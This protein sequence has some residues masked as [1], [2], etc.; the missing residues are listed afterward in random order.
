MRSKSLLVSAIALLLLTSATRPGPAAPLRSPAPGL[1][2]A[3]FAGGCFWSM[4]SAFE[5]KPGVRSVISGYTG[6]TKADPTYDQVSTGTTGHLEAIQVTYDPKVT[7]YAALLDI[8]WH[9]IDP[10]QADGQFYDRAAEYHTAIFY[11]NDAERRVAETSLA[12][13]GAKLRSPV[14]TQL[15]PVAPF[16]AAEKYHQDFYRTNSAYYHAYRAGS[17]RDARLK[18]LWGQA[19]VIA[20]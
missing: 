15:R 20:H 9:N 1:A 10:T 18:Q 4:E 12:A 2:T 11:G 3:N 19:P 16:Y 17:G 6:G 14:A 13:V 8:F 5:G 7:S